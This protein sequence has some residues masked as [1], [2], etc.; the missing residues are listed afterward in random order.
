M[1]LK[2][3]SLECMNNAASGFYL[4]VI[5]CLSKHSPSHFIWSPVLSFAILAFIAW[6]AVCAAGIF[7]AFIAFAYWSQS[8]SSS[9][10]EEPLPGSAWHPAKIALAPARR[11]SRASF[12]I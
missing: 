9:L 8:P 11:M 3:V 2:G 6:V 12:F 4:L 5:L 1:K 10:E 7:P